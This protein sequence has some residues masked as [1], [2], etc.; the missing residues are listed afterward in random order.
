MPMLT[1]LTQCDKKGTDVSIYYDT[2]DNPS[3]AGG[4]TCTSPVWVFHKG[5]TGDVTIT[6]TESEEELSSRDPSLLYRQYSESKRDLEVSGEQLVDTL[7]EGFI[8]FN[9]MRAGS[10]ARNLLILTGYISVL[11]N[12]GFKGKWRNFEATISGPET[13]SQKQNYK[14]KPAAC[15]KSGCYIAPVITRAASTI[16]TYNP[17][18][19]AT[20]DMEALANEIL[21]HDIYR[22]ITNT[23]A[24]EIFT[25]VG[26]I[27]TWLGEEKVDSLLMNLVEQDRVLPEN[28]MLTGRRGGYKA[29]GLGGFNRD[30]LV[31]ALNEIIANALGAEVTRDP[32]RKPQ[33]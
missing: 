4:S 19:F 11:D 10:Y 27:I 14:L 12:V 16:A 17:G 15:V 3:I 29:V 8:Y 26:P 21:K 28:K 18:L 25:D 30:A 6:E 20:Y 7:Y 5:I 33:A 2:A 31:V 32:I 23:T 9:S 24:E 22:G 13:G 1:D